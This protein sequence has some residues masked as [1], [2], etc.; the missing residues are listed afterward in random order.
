MLRLR[1][2]LQTE[3]IFNTRNG[4][5]SPSIFPMA[6]VCYDVCTECEECCL[7]KKEAACGTHMLLIVV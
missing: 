7:I 1:P 2:I 5:E 3:E 4:P 6:V